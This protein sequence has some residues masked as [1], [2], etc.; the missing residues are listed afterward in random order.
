[1]NVIFNFDIY[2]VV[3]KA[4]SEN[5][6]LLGQNLAAV[7]KY[8]NVL[9]V[10]GAY[11]YFYSKIENK[12]VYSMVLL[13]LILVVIIVVRNQL[14][15]FLIS[16]SLIYILSLKR[17]KFLQNFKVFIVLITV[18]PFF[19]SIFGKNLTALINKFEFSGQ[20]TNRQF[21][22]DGTYF[23]RLN[24]IDQAYKSIVGNDVLLLGNGYQRESSVGTYDYVFGAD[25][26]I[27]SILYTEGFIGLSLRSLFLIL[28]FIY[29]LKNVRNKKK[30]L[31]SVLIISIIFPELINIVQT[32]LLAHYSTTIFIVFVLFIYE[33]KVKLIS[34]N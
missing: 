21:L 15:V 5:Y 27:A 4:D 30:V 28:L 18:I 19:L 8:L 16:L 29:G 6:S 25:T 14:I 12:R 31:G 1:M 3:I 13:P 7:P 22:S 11:S 10:F 34:K 32:K 2:Q 17:I 26:L 23:F 33:H 24:L 20:I 9:L